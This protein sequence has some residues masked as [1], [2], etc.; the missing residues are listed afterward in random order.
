MIQVV[1]PELLM[2]E[3]AESRTTLRPGATAE[4]PSLLLGRIN[5]M[6]WEER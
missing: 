1:E 6:R 5:A 3:H 2:P 4:V